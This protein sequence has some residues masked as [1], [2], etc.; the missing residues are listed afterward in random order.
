[1]NPA[2]SDH[3]P[4]SPAAVG[5][6]DKL[7]DDGRAAA[8][9]GAVGSRTWFALYG[10]CLA[11]LSIPLYLAGVVMAIPRRLLLPDSSTLLRLNEGLV[12]YSGLPLTAGC[13]LLALDLW[14]KV[15]HSRAIRSIANIPDDSNRLTVALTAYNDELSIAASVAD[16]LAHPRVARVIVVSNNSADATED[17]ARA[18]G[19]IVHNEPRQGYGS[20]VHRALT[21]AIRFT[22]TA[23]TVLC[24]GDM[25]FRA[26]DIDKLLAYLPH[27]DIVNGTRIVEQLQEKGNQLSLFMHY[28]NLYVGKLLEMKHLGM[29]TLTDV[30]TTYKLCRNQSLTRLLPHLDPGVNMEFNP[31]LLDVALTRGLRIIECPVTFHPRVGVSKGGNVSN[32]VATRVGLRMIAGILTDWI[33]FRR[34]SSGS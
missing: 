6:T 8:H 25:T 10:F 5:P 4:P 24:E 14:R 3:A 2:S 34:A 27:G 33:F 15:A 18:A 12:W 21:E 26:A 13:L 29:V 28:G 7:P 20:C 31:Y 11:S 9:D 22:D 32:A 19:A 23:L 1:M 16:F 30:G 17:Q